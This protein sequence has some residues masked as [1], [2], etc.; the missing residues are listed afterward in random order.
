MGD[1]VNLTPHNIV[2]MRDDGTK[3]SIPPSGDVLRVKTVYNHVGELLGIPIC[4]VSYDGYTGVPYTLDDNTTYIASTFAAM[5]LKL[6]NVVSPETGK[7]CKRD[8]KGRVEY[9]TRF[10]RFYEVEYE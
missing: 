3:I 1:I 5:I 10:Q 8:E 9:S 6:H 4:M 7:T 2:M